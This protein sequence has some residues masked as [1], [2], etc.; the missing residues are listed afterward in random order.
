MTEPATGVRAVARVGTPADQPAGPARIT[1]VRRA[2]Q[3]AGVHILQVLFIEALILAALALFAHGV[4]AATAGGLTALILIFATLAR[5]HGRWW[6]EHWAMTR[7]FRHRNAP[8]ADTAATDPLAGLRLLAPGLSIVELN[9][10]P[11]PPADPDAA[12]AL[13]ET[14]LVMPAVGNASTVAVARDSAGWFGAVQVQPATTM[15]AEVATSLPLA[16][17]V[18]TLSATA[19]SGVL[20][21]VVTQARPDLGGATGDGPAARS[22]RDLTTALRHA[23]APTD[24][25]CWLAVRLDA[26]ELA[27]AGADDEAAQRAPEVVAALIRLIIRTLDHTGLRAIPLDRS[28]L[29][30]ALLAS[31]GLDDPARAPRETWQGWQTG[32]VSHIG[33]WIRDWP[34]PAEVSAL[35]R[36]IETGAPGAQTTVATMI[37]IPPPRY[38]DEDDET[39]GVAP[40]DA[41]VRCMVRISTA[42]TLVDAAHS[43]VQKC[44]DDHNARLQRLDGEHGPAVYATAPTGGGAW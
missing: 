32:E 15:V 19:Q 21:Q 11:A 35:L 41:T 14:T 39:A 38:V 43:A 30:R 5:Q 36:S 44:A 40:T 7:R 9:L 29:Q 20:L 16:R 2:G 17:L 42:T 25:V 10:N 31:C 22:Y 13:D 24:R 28:A 1:P 18:R 12:T 3:F 34:D 6:P 37:A 33:Y 4:I 23:Q 8:P 26:Y 27:G